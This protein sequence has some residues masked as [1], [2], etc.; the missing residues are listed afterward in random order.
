M[1]SLMAQFQD[2]AFSVTEP[3]GVLSS[4]VTRSLRYV[5]SSGN[6][7]A[8]AETNA[9]ASSKMMTVNISQHD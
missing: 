7:I 2:G 8:R 4:G 5:P 1:L 6:Y 9:E 3:L